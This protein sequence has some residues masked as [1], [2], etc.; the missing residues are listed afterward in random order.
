MSE[1]AALPASPAA[2]PPPAATPELQP[3]GA[4]LHA[5]VARERARLAER[6]AARAAADEQAADFAWL[7]SSLR[8]N[9]EAATRKAAKAAKIAPDMLERALARHRADHAAAEGGEISP[10]A[11]P[12]RPGGASGAGDAGAPGASSA[13]SGDEGGGWKPAKKPIVPLPEDC[14]VIPVGGAAGAYFYLTPK[15]ELRAVTK[16]DANS[17]RTLFGERQDYLWAHHRKFN[18]QTGDQDGWKADR[19]SETLIDACARK[20]LFDPIRRLRGAGGWTDRDGGLILHCGD[21]LLVDGDWRKPGLV[22]DLVYP[23]MDALPRPLDTGDPAPH[24]R[25]LAELLDEFSWTNGPEEAGVALADRPLGEG[26]PKLATLLV[27]GHQLAVIAGAALA[28]RPILWFTGDAGSGKSL[29]MEVCQQLH[30]GGL[31]KS[32]D[33]TPAGVYLTAGRS[34]LGVAIDEAENEANNPRMRAMVKLARSSATGAMGLRGTDKLTGTAFELKSA[35]M[36][37]SILIPPMLPQDLSRTAIMDMGP[38]PGGK[39]FHMDKPRL[40][41]TGRALRRRLVEGWARLPATM[42]AYRVALVAQGHNQRSCDQWGTLLALADLALEDAAPHP[43][44]IDAL[45][46]ALARSRL[47]A[48]HYVT[49]NAEAMLNHVTTAQVNAF[50]GGVQRT[51]GQLVA[52]AAGLQSDEGQ[53]GSA[54]TCVDT[55]ATWGVFVT[56]RRAE[57]RVALPNQH[58]GLL[59]LFA[60]SIWA[61]EPGATGAWTQAMRRLPGV[62]A[63]NSR[64]IGGRGFSVP[65]RVFLQDDGSEA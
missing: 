50:R 35:F 39:S 13:P 1:P 7:L 18:K 42:E 65:V 57:A 29:I 2:G 12:S 53:D 52:M 26:T 9:G 55:L 25:W 44:T 21:A 33:A 14:P 54:Q 11:P 19:W 48:A 5:E 63:E 60:N 31:L 10:T 40:A 43:D 17:L 46:L 45:A 37:G 36:L 8:R 23:A 49:T 64:K 62:R 15:S 22:D 20:P 16:F 3:L 41:L 32:A 34:C 28:Y 61:G 59:K 4:H 58:G 6:E 47:D 56:G 30:G 51:I 27:I 38:A 24:I